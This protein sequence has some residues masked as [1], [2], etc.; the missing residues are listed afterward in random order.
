MKKIFR[1]I[2]NLFF[3]ASTAFIVSG[4]GGSGGGGSMSGSVS[5]GIGGGTGTGDIIN[6]TVNTPIV[7]NPEPSTLLLFGSA[8]LGMAVYAKAKYIKGKKR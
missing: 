6:A 7:H 5:G 3:T 1:A 4:C 8:L 2:Y